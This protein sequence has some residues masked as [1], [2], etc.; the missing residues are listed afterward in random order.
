MASSN[1]AAFIVTPIAIA[2]FAVLYNNGLLTSIFVT[3][4]SLALAISLGLA[5]SVVVVDTGLNAFGSRLTFITTFTTGVFIGNILS[6]LDLYLSIPW[7]FG[8]IMV[9]VFSTMFALGIFGLVSGG[10]GN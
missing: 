6:G 4:G 7:G 1:D 3:V 10:S 5:S 2:I 9:G 8:I